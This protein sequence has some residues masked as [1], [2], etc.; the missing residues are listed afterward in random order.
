MIP[1]V[2]G[3][4]EKKRVFVCVGTSIHAYVCRRVWDSLYTEKTIWN[5]TYQTDSINTIFNGGK[6]KAFPPRLGTREGWPPSPLFL[7]RGLEVLARAIKQHKEIKHSQSRKGEVKLLLFA[8]DRILYTEKSQR[9]KPKT[10][11]TNKN[12]WVSCR[13]QNQ[14][15]EINCISIHSE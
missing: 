13:I 12:L 10:V 15:T 11:G 2:C 7:N 6:W 14:H 1:F 5:N 3:S 4:E 8:D 9:R